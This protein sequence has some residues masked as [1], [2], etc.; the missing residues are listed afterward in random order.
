MGFVCIAPVLAAKVFGEFNPELTIGNDPDTARKIEEMGGIH[1]N[2]EVGQ[3]AVD[4]VNKIVSTPAYMLGPS[5]SKIAEGIEK[6][7]DKVVEL[8]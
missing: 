5:I 1:I 4:E 8:A 3:I 7:A 6:L 2:C